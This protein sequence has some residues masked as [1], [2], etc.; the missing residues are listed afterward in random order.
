MDVEGCNPAHKCSSMQNKAIV[1]VRK[2]TSHIYL[3]IIPESQVCRLS[4]IINTET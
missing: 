1:I 3:T 4:V 2:Y